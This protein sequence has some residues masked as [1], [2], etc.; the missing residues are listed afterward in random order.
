VVA[1]VLWGV[2]TLLLQNCRHPFWLKIKDKISLLCNTAG[3]LLFV[4]SL[5][6]YAATF[7]FVFLMIKVFLLMKKA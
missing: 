7:L 1:T 5:Q 2:F 4:V 6:P 3:V